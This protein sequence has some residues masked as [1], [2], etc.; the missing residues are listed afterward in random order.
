MPK[1]FNPEETQNAVLA[2]REDFRD[3][4][5]LANP[6]TP[7]NV[8]QMLGLAQARLQALALLLEAEPAVVAKLLDQLVWEADLSEDAL[9]AA[10]AE[11]GLPQPVISSLNSGMK[12]HRSTLTELLAR[13]KGAPRRA[14]RRPNFVPSPP[15]HCA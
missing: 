5:G 7:S 2:F 11:A 13:A 9:S 1:E 6:S 4:Y 15:D 8:G 14:R 10:R 12:A 3:R